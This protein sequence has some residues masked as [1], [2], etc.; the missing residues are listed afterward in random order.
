MKR[1]W[2]VVGVLL[3]FSCGAARA[4]DALS[5]R[6]QHVG[7]RLA[8]AQRLARLS[9][10]DRVPPQVVA[11]WSRLFVGLK[12]AHIPPGLLVS[13]AFEGLLKGVPPDRITYALRL[14]S[15]NLFWGARLLRRQTP[16]IHLRARAGRAA[17]AAIV[18][19]RR[20]LTTPH[21]V[22]VVGRQPLPVAR[23]TALIEVAANL[24][25]AGISAQ[26]LVPVLR[27]ARRHGVRARTLWQH[28]QVFLQEQAQGSTPRAWRHFA[29][30]VGGPHG[31]DQGLIHSGA[32]MNLARPGSYAGMGGL[33]GSGGASPMGPGA[34]N[35]PA[36]GGGMGGMGSR[37][38]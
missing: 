21:I 3:A 27:Y 19:A 11:A 37:V 36:P 20:S 9:R 32:S 7:L 23:L 8:T 15:R 13:Q 30:A 28:D 2:M 25:N 10:E 4:H 24:K 6:F 1:A 33:T 29:L 38:P 31:L 16:Q 18:V 5:A 17:L 34:I 22:A 12:D 14:T 26:Q 35:G